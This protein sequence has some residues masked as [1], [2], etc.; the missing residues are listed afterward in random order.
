MWPPLSLC[1]MSAV[2][3]LVAW[4][5][6]HFASLST[7]LT[8]ASWYLWCAINSE[9]EAPS[10][11]LSISLRVISSWCLTLFD[12][13]RRWSFK[14][15]VKPSWDFCWWSANISLTSERSGLGVIHLIL[16]RSPLYQ[17]LVYSRKFC[18]MDKAISF[19]SGVKR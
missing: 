6:F 5:H 10:D 4:L 2:S 8:V 7:L 18:F 16:R 17:G 14:I 11:V 3:F 15:L 12:A 13:C 19:F 1:L 9:A